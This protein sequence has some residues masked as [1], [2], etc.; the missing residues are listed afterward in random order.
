MVLT[1]MGAGATQIKR[2]SSRRE[3]DTQA[4]ET[5]K[6]AKEMKQPLELIINVTQED[7]DN[8]TQG[9]PGHCAIAQC[10]KRVEGLS[11]PHVNG[12]TITFTYLGELFRCHCSHV[13]S[14]WISIFDGDRKKAKPERFILRPKAKKAYQANEND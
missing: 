1:G 10:M 9:A 7:I 3:S 2:S 12:S 14:G 11:D 4:E 5:K 8:S 13:I 6:E